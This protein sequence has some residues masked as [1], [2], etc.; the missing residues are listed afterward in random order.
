MTYGI[1]KSAVLAALRARVEADLEAVTRS[2]L[3]TV[4]GA[5]HEESR[6]ENDKDTRAL[7]STY[8]ARGLAQRVADLTSAA[9][10]LAN[11][12]VRSFGDDDPIALS[13]LVTVEDGDGRAT[14]YFIAP[15][16]GGLEVVVDG[17]AVRIVTPESP[18]GRQLSGKH[19]GD[20]IEARGKAGP[21]VLVIEDI[22]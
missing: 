15:A 18:L 16:G 19:A 10:M 8:L 22:A 14:H 13:A 20:E 1:V 2:Q 7:E 9:S 3:E 5:T 12:A 11:L 17:V 21:R 6:P 4:A